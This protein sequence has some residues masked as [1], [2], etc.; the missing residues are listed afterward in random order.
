[1]LYQRTFA[2]LANPDSDALSG[3]FIMRGVPRPEGP[4]PQS[5]RRGRSIGRTGYNRR[6]RRSAAKA[7][8][9]NLC[10][11]SGRLERAQE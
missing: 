4:T 9:P 1:M 10:S 7:A 3:D 5:L 11:P 2:F 8:W 6:A